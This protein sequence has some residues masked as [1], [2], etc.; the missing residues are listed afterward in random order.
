MDK[1]E[2]KY[3]LKDDDKTEAFHRGRRMFCIYRGE[4]VVAD[5]NL[6]YNHATW[7]EKEG[8]M[9]KEDDGLMDK[10]TRGI[11]DNNGDVYFYV[12]YDFKV[13][14]EIESEFFSH[15]KELAGELNLDPGAMV[16]GGLVKSDSGK[17]WPAVK[18]YGKVADIA[19]YNL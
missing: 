5:K 15:I 14:D 16:Y 8:W 6:P 3:G 9:S 19:K 4:L 7:F 13:N 17:T 12:G 18:E 11:V 1:F 10:M 2:Q